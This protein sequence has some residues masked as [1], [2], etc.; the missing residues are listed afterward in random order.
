ME[1]S[2]P[3]DFWE[4]ASKS[5]LE[6]SMEQQTQVETSESWEPGSLSA[7][8][9]VRMVCPLLGSR[10]LEVHPCPQL[11]Q[12][13]VLWLPFLLAYSAPPTPSASLSGSKGHLPNGAVTGDQVEVEGDF[14]RM[15]VMVEQYGGSDGDE[16]QGG[17]DHSQYNAH[18]GEA[19]VFQDYVTGLHPCWLLQ[20]HPLLFKVGHLEQADV[21]MA[22][23]QKMDS[24]GEGLVPLIG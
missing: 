11:A 15:E 17:M 5:C 9:L 22:S 2:H 16:A 7:A 14:L 1:P 18:G 10:L 21:H 8:E 13:G 6:M 4:E 24:R 20:E 19:G 23:C 12:Q 3:F